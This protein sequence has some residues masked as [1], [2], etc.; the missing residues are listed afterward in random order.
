MNMLDS[1]KASGK[2]VLFVG[3]SLIDDVLG[4]QKLGIKRVG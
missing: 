4:S 2:E 1:L 3:D